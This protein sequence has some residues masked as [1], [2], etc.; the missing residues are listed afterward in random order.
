ME[1]ARQ[2]FPCS[3]CGADL[4]F[5]PGVDALHCPYCGFDNPIAASQEAVVEN[6]YQAALAHLKEAPAAASGGEQAHC[7]TCGAT[8]RSAEYL[9][10][11]ACPYCGASV[12]QESSEFRP[13]QPKA[14]LPF[15]IPRAKA[16]E[17]FRN[18]IGGL[19][20]APGKLKRMGH[21]ET[22]LVGIYVPYWTYDADTDS[23]YRGERGEDYW[24]DETYRATENGQTVLKTRQVQRTR[25][26]PAA[27]NVSLNFDDVLVVAGTALPRDITDRL[28]P[29]DLENLVDYDPQY[30]S[31]FQSELYGL[32]LEQGF[33]VAQGAMDA[34]IRRAVENQIG[35]DRQRIHQLETSY[36]QV[37]F[38]H[39]LLPVWS[40]A[41]VYGGKTYRFVV[42]GR[43][44]EI[45]GQRPWS[46]AKI[47]SAI[48]L[49]VLLVAMF[50]YF[51]G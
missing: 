26:Y 8:F 43:T 32:G 29:W 11:D 49:A 10:A 39:I 19:W 1:R 40:S 13:I 15:S 7:R 42:N 35:G 4:K 38:K 36:S 46:W 48:L 51:G 27:G 24:E 28:E 20:F 5:A 22:A 37:T 6:D 47:A 9:H 34:G 31:G 41:F 2:S 30:L 23:D 14:L 50:Y 21:H 18:W 45:Q 25:W 33:H 17:I 12:V 44:G 3:Q 16:G